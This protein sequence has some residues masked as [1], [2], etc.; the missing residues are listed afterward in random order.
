MAEDWQGLEHFELVQKIG[1]GTFG[2]VYKA[3]ALGGPQS[4]ENCR[5]R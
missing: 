3:K 5:I 4:G 2:V 1:E